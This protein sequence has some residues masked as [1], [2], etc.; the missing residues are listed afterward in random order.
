MEIPP[1][2]LPSVTRRAY[3]VDELASVICKRA[4]VIVA[5]GLPAK[6]LPVVSEPVVAET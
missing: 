1:L 4:F 3:F 6:P 5:Q 2:Y